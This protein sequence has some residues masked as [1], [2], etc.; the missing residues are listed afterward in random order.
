MQEPG[1][2]GIKFDTFLGPGVQVVVKDGRR[3]VRH[4]ER[5]NLVCAESRGRHRADVAR[6]SRSTGMAIPNEHLPY[7]HRSCHGDARN[8]RASPVE[9]R[10]LRPCNTSRVV[11]GSHR[12]P[13]CPHH[14]LLLVNDRPRRPGSLSSIYTVMVSE[15]NEKGVLW[16]VAAGGNHHGSKSDM[17]AMEACTAQ[18]DEAGR[19]VRTGRRRGFACTAEGSRL[20]LPPRQTA[21]SKWVASLPRAGRSPGR[22]CCSLPRAIPIVGVPMNERP[23]RHGL[24]AL[25]GADALRCARGLRGRWRLPRTRQSTPPRSLGHHARSIARRW[26]HEATKCRA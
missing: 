4:V 24:P 20:G 3:I 26:V 2:D 14:L 23:G 16:P 15:P 10:S 7:P 6:R 22:R 12:V 18:L 8:V 1:I 21:V 9:T 11:V 5:G 17:P 25:H 19:S 13:Q